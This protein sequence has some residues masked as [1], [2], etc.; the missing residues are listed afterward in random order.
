MTLP[1]PI[2]KPKFGGKPL[3][4]SEPPGAVSTPTAPRA[5]EAGPAPAPASVEPPNYRESSCADCNNYDI[6]AT[7]EQ[8][9]CRKFGVPVN[10]NGSCDDFE[11]VSFG[12]D[13]EDSENTD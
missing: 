1:E 5:P 8:S 2:G 11:Y 7:G 6:D 10:S 9:M 3:R 13:S 4:T 12:D